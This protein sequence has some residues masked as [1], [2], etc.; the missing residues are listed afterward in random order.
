M[1]ELSQDVTAIKEGGG[2]GV[3]SLKALM[4]EKLTEAESKV[5][6]VRL[7]MNRN[8]KMICT[9]VLFRFF[10]V[11]EVFDHFQQEFEKKSEATDEKLDRIDATVNDFKAAN[12]G[13]ISDV[14]KDSQELKVGG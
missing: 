4:E 5:M 3:E 10:Q 2:A 8:I 9:H 12:E 11:K 13:H 14:V 7:I 1:S 6:E